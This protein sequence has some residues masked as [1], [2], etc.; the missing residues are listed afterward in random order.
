[1]E[2]DSFIKKIFIFN[3]IS[4]LIKKVEKTSLSFQRSINDF[5]KAKQKNC[6]QIEMKRSDI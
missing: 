3:K 1:M 5:V 2:R 4:I 6:G